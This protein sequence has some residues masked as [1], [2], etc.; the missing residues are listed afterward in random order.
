M[1]LFPEKRLEYGQNHGLV[2]ELL[3]NCLFGI[4]PSKDKNTD[5]GPKFKTVVSRNVALRLLGVL[6]K[7]AKDNL[8]QVI[9]YLM[10]LHKNAPWRTKKD[11]DWKIT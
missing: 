2:V 4:K 6:C 11:S 5:H 8:I 10:P 7:D 9:N 3:D 1:F